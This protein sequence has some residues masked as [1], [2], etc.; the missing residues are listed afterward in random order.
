MMKKWIL[1]GLL[2]CLAYGAQAQSGWSVTPRVGMQV[3]VMQSNRVGFYVGATAQY[4]FGPVWALQMGAM[5]ANGYESYG[6]GSHRAEHM[7]HFPIQ[8][9]A[10]VRKGWYWATGPQFHMPFASST[11]WNDHKTTYTDVEGGVSWMIGTG[12]DFP[13]GLT[14]NVDYAYGS[15]VAF[16]SYIGG[17]R[18]SWNLIQIGFGWRF[19][20]GK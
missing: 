18:P 4:R 2:M 10:Y 11:R 8:V 19:G 15:P 20:K 16:M 6:N 7:L 17:G 12:Y 14:V 13:C 3:A 5:Y 1:G 9:K